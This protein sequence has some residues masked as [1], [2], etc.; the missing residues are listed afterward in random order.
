MLA[1]KNSVVF[2]PSWLDGCALWR[3]YMP[4]Q[5]MHGS[6][7]HCFADKIDFEYVVGS[8]VCVVQR[9]FLQQQFDFMKLAVGCGMRLIWDLDDNVWDIPAF[10][11]ASKPLTKARLGFENCVRMADVVTV[12]TKTLAKVVKRRVKPLVN[13]RGK[14]IPI[15]VAENKLYPPVFAEP[16]K[17]D[18]E[19]VVIGWAGS[20]SHVGD[21]Q[22]VEDA[23]LAIAKEPNVQIEFRGCKLQDGSP[24]L[25]LKNFEFKYGCHVAEYTTRMPMWNWDIALAPLVKH[26]FNDS[27]SCIKMVEAG[28]CKIPCLV[29]YARPYEDFCHHDKELEWLLCAGSSA[30]ESKMRI[31]VNEKARR[32]ELGE[33]MRAVVDKHYT[34]HGQHEAWSEAIALAMR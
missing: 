3:L 23:I 25:D 24:L 32:V 7:L 29:S 9:C 34:I 2:I 12:S 20:T 27:K 1:R 33:R 19:N 16:I 17:Q 13:F 15:V 28:W 18:R 6:R 10:N 26:D 11:P 14:E 8:D 4:H 22:V 5:A 30:Y 21:L 31:L